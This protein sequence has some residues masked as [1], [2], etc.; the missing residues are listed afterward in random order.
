MQGDLARPVGGGDV[1]VQRQAPQ[2]GGLGVRRPQ[3]EGPFP[4]ARGQ[5]AHERN[6][7]D[8][9]DVA[10]EGFRRQDLDDVMKRQV[11]PGI[12]LDSATGE[13]RMDDR[14]RFRG[15]GGAP[16]PQCVLLCALVASV[17]LGGGRHGHA[18]DVRPLK[19]NGTAVRFEIRRAGGRQTFLFPAISGCRYRLTA[20]PGTLPRPRLAIGK[21][22]GDVFA[23]ADGGENGKAA[24]YVWDSEMDER[25]TV[26]VT[27]FS[28][29]TGDGTL[30]LQTLA[31]D[32]TPTRP[33]RRMLAV[34]ATDRAQVGHLLIGGAN[35][36]DLVVEP[37]AAYQIT[38]TVGSAGR[39]RLKVAVGEDT[40]IADSEATGLAVRPHPP[41][42]FRAPADSDDG[43]APPTCWLEVRGGFDG[44][45]SYG[46]RMRR[47]REGETVAPPL[48]AP[49]PVPAAEQLP[50]PI[51]TFR[52]GPGDL[53]LLY[54][55][56]ANNNP[57]RVQ[58]LRGDVWVEVEQRGQGASARTHEWRGMNWFRPFSPGTFRFMGA[59]GFTPEDAQLQLFRRED[60]GGAPIHLGT[61]V[62]PEVRVRVGKKW[63]LAGLG[64]CMP[65]WDYLFVAVGAPRVG[66]SMRVVDAKG[67]T[68]AKRGSTG[69]TYVADT[70]P[71]LRFQPKAPGLFRLEVRSRKKRVVAALLR[72]AS[73]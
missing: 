41:V 72:H 23:D 22:K 20:T 7:G 37:G 12:R 65:G 5:I 52:A 13:K 62:D 21:W 35:K 30:R 6:E 4:L 50:G 2:R 8:R 60:L 43:A 45:G 19:A 40:V 15:H 36:W 34:R 26:T 31:P 58:L 32:D 53:A 1:H 10:R 63:T 67:K 59:Q 68:V 39:V 47:L 48:K 33:H 17:V 24:T 55:P 56:N 25:L 70:G 11:A 9:P 44:G 64:A 54:V 18:E 27:G 57:H 61:G 3:N 49:P 71:S 42:R 51:P 29:Q 14:R 46:L 66:V 73:N 69:A 16:Y 38:P 28:A